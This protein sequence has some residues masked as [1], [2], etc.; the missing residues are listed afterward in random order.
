MPNLI[1][2]NKDKNL[3]KEIIIIIKKKRLVRPE[4][5]LTIFYYVMLFYYNSHFLERSALY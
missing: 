3:T 1:K 4:A 5:H 2:C